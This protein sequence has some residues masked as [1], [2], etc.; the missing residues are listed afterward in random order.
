[1][2]SPR[3]L[4]YKPY[5]ILVLTTLLSACVA[6]PPTQT[7]LSQLALTNALQPDHWQFAQTPGEFDAAAL[8]FSLPTGLLELIKEAQLHNPDL[9]IAATRVAQAQAALTV[10]G[11]SLLPSLVLGGEAGD[12]PIP[13]ASIT[14]EGL[15][16]LSNWEIDLWGKTR[17]AKAAAQA[18]SLA[19]ELDNIYT[20][21]SGRGC[22]QILARRS[23]S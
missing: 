8:G 3:H 23:R 1:M 7:E 13:A 2:P 9:R 21:I 5:R 4:S 17:S 6:T 18:N 10:A 20:P 19:A 12:S 22:C 15:G 14:T 11:A 16:L